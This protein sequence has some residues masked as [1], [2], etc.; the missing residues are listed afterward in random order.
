M[1]IALSQSI[2]ASLVTT[3]LPS[4]GALASPGF[5]GPPTSSVDWCEANY[6]HTR[7]VAELFNTTS[8]LAMVL[9]GLLGLLLH[10][11]SLE[12]RF[13]LCFA[14]LVI[15]GLGSVGFHATLRFELQMADEL[16][17][18]YTA[19]VMLYIL[20]ENQRERRFGSWFPLLLAAHALLVT[21]LTAF[22]RGRLQFYLFHTS[23]G[24]MEAF[25]LYGVY[26]LHRRQPLSPVGK[27]FHV[28]I[29]AYLVA[30]VLWFID[31]RFCPLLSGLP[32]HGGFNPQLHAVWHVLV[33]C[34]FYCL[35]L[36]VAY[37]RLETLRRRPQLRRWAGVPYVASASGQ[38]S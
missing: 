24:S 26:R 34:G 27:L 7:W 16:P 20:L 36:V 28:G 22:A 29:A 30:I 17:M 31:L 8:S 18:L 5:W 23:F 35:L 32:A 21:S 25:S 2:Q 13:A 11:R 3:G 19:I 33:S 15:V 10:R 1:L 4:S 14:S 12:R 9:A 6:A 38:H 37:H